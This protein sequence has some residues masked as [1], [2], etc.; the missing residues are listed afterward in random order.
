MHTPNEFA[1]LEI[2]RNAGLSVKNASSPRVYQA[3]RAHQASPVQLVKLA[4]QVL[5]AFLVAKDHQVEMVSADQRASEAHPV[6]EKDFPASTVVM[7][8]QVLQAAL[9]LTVFGD[10][11]VA[12]V[13]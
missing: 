6:S 7:A 3:P 12:T 8:F 11:K 2:Q 5:Q 10:D 9:V 13:P 1:I 4:P